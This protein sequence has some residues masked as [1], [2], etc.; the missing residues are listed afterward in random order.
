[1]STIEQFER[2]RDSGVETNKEKREQREA[3]KDP[4]LAAAA[5]LE[6]ADYLVKEVK[7]NKQQM[8]NI[9][10]HMQQVTKAIQ[11]IRQQLNIS[12]QGHDPS[13]VQDAA[14]IKKLQTLI[15][16]YK[17]ELLAMKDDLIAMQQIELQKQNPTASPETIAAEAE[18]MVVMMIGE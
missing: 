11:S 5:T 7:S 18:R 10:L 8:Q 14:Q 12:A 3:E 6:R 16:T 15:E 17:T 1:M 9:V 2:K 13:L 4:E